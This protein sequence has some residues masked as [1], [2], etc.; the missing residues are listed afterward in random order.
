MTAKQLLLHMA[1]QS[2]NADEM[3]LLTGVFPWKWQPP[4]PPVPDADRNLTDEAARTKPDCWHQSIL[5]ILV[6]VGVCKVGYMTQAFGEPA[7]ALPEIGRTLESVLTYLDAAQALVVA[8]LEAIDEGDLGK[9]VTTE[10]HGQSA[11]NLFWVLAQHDVAHG[12]QIDVLRAS[13]GV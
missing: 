1:R 8:C 4:G 13:L 10:Y 2:Y 5:D 7:E 9:P 11:A 3:A 12:S 6:H